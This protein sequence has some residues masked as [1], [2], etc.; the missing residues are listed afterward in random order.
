MPE[1][2][3]VPFTAEYEE[4]LLGWFANEREM[5]Q[6]S[7]EGMTWPLTRDQLVRLREVPTY[8]GT[9]QLLF[10]TLS[11]GRAI[12][13]IEVLRIDRGKG[14]G[15][16]GRILVAPGERRQ[17]LGKATVLTTLELMRQEGLRR[18][19][20]C[21]Y[22]WNKAAIGLYRSLGFVDV[23]GTACMTWVGTEEWSSFD[24]ALELR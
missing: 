15:R 3:L 4:Q 10:T 22:T 8:P 2:I 16:I 6:W 9:E 20:L 1:V 14:A 17:G 21:V 18:V 19:S 24:M 12:G 7:G 13:H 23:P 11:E 5:V